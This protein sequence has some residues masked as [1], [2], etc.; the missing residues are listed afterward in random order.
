MGKLNATVNGNLLAA[1]PPTAPCYKSV[2]SIPTYNATA[3]AKV[4]ANFTDEQWTY[5]HPHVLTL[6][7]S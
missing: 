4:R 2:E 3:C 6:V 1:L 7:N 5:V